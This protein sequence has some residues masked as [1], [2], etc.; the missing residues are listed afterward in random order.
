MDRQEDG[1]FNPGTYSK[2]WIYADAV[3][4]VTDAICQCT[5]CRVCLG[6]RQFHKYSKRIGLSMFDHYPYELAILNP[7]EAAL[8]S[9]I[10][11]TIRIFRRQHYQQTHAVGQTLICWNSTQSVAQSLPCGPSDSSILLLTEEH[12]KSVLDD[13]LLRTAAI[14]SALKYLKE[15]IEQYE[16]VAINTE[17]MHVLERTWCALFSQRGTQNLGTT[18]VRIRVKLH[19][20]VAVAPRAHWT[21]YRALPASEGNNRCHPAMVN[22][23]PQ[24]TPRPPY[25]TSSLDASRETGPTQLG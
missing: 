13:T 7:L 14:V 4:Q 1:T 10:I 25:V 16:T 17:S 20:W 5:S 3:C 6:K 23:P 9:T 11:P 24:T 22:Q 19:L 21:L 18:K 15:H 2:Y 12:G 8:V